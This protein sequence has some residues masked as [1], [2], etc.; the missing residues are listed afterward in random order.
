MTIDP[1]ASI[2]SSNPSALGVWADGP[3]AEIKAPSIMTNPPG[4]TLRPASTVTT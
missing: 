1:P 4:K 2:T 3:T